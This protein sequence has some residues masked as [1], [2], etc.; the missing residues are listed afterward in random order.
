MITT[1]FIISTAL[2]SFL[3]LRRGPRL[4]TILPFFLLILH[5]LV[6]SRTSAS[7]RKSDRLSITVKM[8]AAPPP[9]H[10]RDVCLPPRRQTDVNRFVGVAVVFGEH[11]CMI[12]DATEQP[13]TLSNRP[14]MLA[15]SCWLHTCQRTAHDTIVGKGGSWNR[16]AHLFSSRVVSFVAVVYVYH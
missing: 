9:H 6:I 11:T 7:S 12:D 8:C 10:Q 5:M 3:W 2:P 15:S 14:R 4:T 1:L 13:V 16:I